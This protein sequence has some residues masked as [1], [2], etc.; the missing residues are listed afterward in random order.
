MLAAIKFLLTIKA[1]AEARKAAVAAEVKPKPL[2]I[3]KRK[4][5]KKIIMKKLILN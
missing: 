4:N 2:K 5:I 1:V 3:K